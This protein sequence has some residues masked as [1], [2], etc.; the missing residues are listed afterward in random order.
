ME[1]KSSEVE[2]KPRVLYWNP[3]K[4]SFKEEGVMSEST[5]FLNETQWHCFIYYRYSLHLLA[6]PLFFSPIQIR[7]TEVSRT[8]SRVYLKARQQSTQENLAVSDRLPTLRIYSKI[9]GSFGFSKK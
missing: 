5:E 9:W 6:V 4:E 1:R 8:L 2:A 7:S 3:S